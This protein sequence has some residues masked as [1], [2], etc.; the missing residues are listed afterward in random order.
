[1][2]TTQYIIS[3][4]ITYYPV[5]SKSYTRRIHNFTIMKKGRDSLLEVARGYAIK[6]I[7]IHQIYT[8]PR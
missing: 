7:K 1:M 8:I 5:G 4:M 3:N 6:N 2:T